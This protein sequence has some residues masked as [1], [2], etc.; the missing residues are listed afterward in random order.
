METSESLSRATILLYAYGVACNIINNNVFVGT[1]ICG[2]STYVRSHVM[3][4]ISTSYSLP[5]CSAPNCYKNGGEGDWC[6]EVCTHL[7]FYG[8]STYNCDLDEE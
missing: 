7:Y 4:G 5:F 3:P 1:F 2:H 8:F 6:Q